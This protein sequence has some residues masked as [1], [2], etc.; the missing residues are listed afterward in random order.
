[1]SVNLAATVFSVKLHLIESV[2]ALAE[3]GVTASHLKFLVKGKVLSDTT[4]V[5]NFTLADL[6]VSITVMVS[7]PSPVAASPAAASTDAASV[8]DEPEP[9]PQ[10]SASTLTKIHELLERDVGHARAESLVNKLKELV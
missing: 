5:G 7:T 9:E 6:P 8:S 10:V 2:S 4:T 3:A 1:M